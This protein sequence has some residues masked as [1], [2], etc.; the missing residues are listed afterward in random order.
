MKRLSELYDGYPDIEIKGIKI[1]SKEIEP[2]DLFVC[3]SGVTADRHDYVN[4]AVSRGCVAIVASKQIDVNV[5]VVY[6]NDTNKELPLVC[7]KFYDNPDTLLDL[8]AITGTNGKTTTAS[9]IQDLMGNDICGYQ[10][11]NGIICSK[12][13][14][15]IVNTTPDADRLYKYFDKFVKAGCKYLSIEVSSEAFFRHRVDNLKFKVGIL[16]NVTQDHLNIHGSIENY[17]ECKKQLFKQV[18][19]DGYS[20]L[21]VDDKY[22]EEFKSIARG[23]IL[24]YGE[25]ESNLQI[26]SI[27]EEIDKTNISLKYEG[28]IYNVVSPLLGKFNVYNL[29]AAI[30]ALLVNGYSMERIIDNIKNIKVPEGRCQF[31]NFGQNYHI[32]LDYAH[33]PDAFSKL[34][35]LLD[36][37]KKNRII[38]VTGSAGGRE[39]EKRPGMGKLVLEHS[40]YVIFTMDDPRE[41]D[42]NKIIDDLVS[43][44]TKTNYERI[45]NRKEAIYKAFDMALKDDII[46][47]AG[48]GID[49]YMAIGKEYV[50]YCDLDVIKKYF[51]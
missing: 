25:K 32:V 42:V 6:V 45:P 47:I 29:C 23:R 12:F 38:T 28:K 4:D 44:T 17:V 41:E 27:K 18:I 34:Y 37:V 11:T 19:D 15:H 33:T 8:I 49:N 24:T 7:R 31:L 20:I 30:L 16:T 51:D 10:G 50:P 13:N 43:D 39:H 46:L 40:D 5:P 48:K 26:L 21:N 22:Y 14:E 1:N 35:D 3:T 9:I 2:G 36:K